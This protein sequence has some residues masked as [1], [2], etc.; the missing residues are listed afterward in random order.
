MILSQLLQPKNNNLDSFRIL[1]ALLVI[2]GHAPAFLPGQAGSDFVFDWLGFD[3]S[4]SLAVKFFFM[5]SGLLVT[6]SLLARPQIFSFLLRRAVRIFPGLFVCIFLSVF[7]LGL[8]VTSLSAGEYLLHPQTLRYWLHNSSLIGLQWELPGVFTAAKTST[9]NGSLWTLPLEVM[10][11]VSL[12]VFYVLILKAHYKIACSILFVLISLIFYGTPLWPGG[13]IRFTESL[14]LGGCF[15]IGS[16]Y[17][18]LQRQLVLGIKGVVLGLV[19]VFLLWQTPLQQFAFYCVFFYTCLYLSGT[20][21]F[22]KI[23][24]LPGDPSYGIYIYGFVIQQCLVMVYPAQGILFN[25][26]AAA[27]IAIIVGYFSWYLIEKPAIQM[28]KKRI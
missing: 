1:A 23:L 9:V 20:T 19:M 18:V 10:C 28:M 8:I 16:F 7:V 14:L 6:H 13:L 5:L 11:Y 12:V 3:Y 25:Q 22:T 21:V 24:K 27:I 17:A 15:C 4:G 26:I 2:Y